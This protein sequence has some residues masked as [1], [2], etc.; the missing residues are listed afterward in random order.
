MEWW[1]VLLFFLKNVQKPGESDGG[2]LLIRLFSIRYAFRP[3]HTRIERIVKCVRTKSLLS[4]C[5]V[6]REFFRGV[7]TLGVS[8]SCHVAYV[9]HS[10]WRCSL[11][12]LVDAVSWER[13]FGP[14]RFVQHEPVY[15]GARVTIYI[16]FFWSLQTRYIPVQDPWLTSRWPPESTSRT[17]PSG[18]K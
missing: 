10:E 3:E 1:F 7:V 4:Y 17:V 8:V 12:I 15:R 18:E 16:F 6:P 5:Q 9:R 13:T 14:L 2:I 11:M